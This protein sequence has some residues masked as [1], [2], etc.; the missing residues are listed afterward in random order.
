MT[1]HTAASVAPC[2]FD[3]PEP[4][5]VS[6]GSQCYRLAVC[7][8]VAR[9]LHDTTKDR[10]AV[11]ADM[12]RLCDREVSKYMLDAYASEGREEFNLPAYLLPVLEAAC[13]SYQGTL[14]LA[15]VRGG[16]FLVGKEALNAE[17]GRLERLRDEAASKIKDLKRLM[18]D[19]NDRP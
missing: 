7:Q 17:L 6:A 16:R 5:P 11:A 10:F 13:D 9:M 3:V 19:Q 1:R 8:L 15:S 14:W 12:S 2:L 4:A 18:G